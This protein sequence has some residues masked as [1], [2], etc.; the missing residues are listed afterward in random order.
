MSSRLRASCGTLC[1]H[2]VAAFVERYPKYLAELEKWAKSKNR[3]VR[4]AAAVTFI[5]PARNGQF[6]D[7]IFEI[8]DL[9]LLDSAA[10]VQKGYGSVLKAASQSH[11]TEVCDYVMR[12][13]HQMPRTALCCAIEK[14][15]AGKRKQQAM[16]KQD[17][18]RRSR[19]RP[20]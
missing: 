12:N 14:M 8:A 9:L 20:A 5:V 15:P 1:K 10:L 13:K 11:E 16:A 18:Q 6:L 7:D 19:K 4:R 3:W 17:V 2:T